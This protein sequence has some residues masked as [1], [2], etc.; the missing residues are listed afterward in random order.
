MFRNLIDGQAADHTVF[1]LEW[2]ADHGLGLD[3]RDHVLL[4]RME[5]VPYFSDVLR[6]DRSPFPKHGGLD[7]VWIRNGDLNRAYMACEVVRG[8]DDPGIMLDLPDRIIR[9][10]DRT[11]I[12]EIVDDG[13]Q[14]M[15]QERL[16]IQRRTENEPGI[17]QRR[18]LSDLLPELHSRLFTVEV[19]LAKFFVARFH[20]VQ[21]VLHQL[22]S[23]LRFFAKVPPSVRQP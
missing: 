18:Q 22:C 1:D 12:M 19:G 20:N 4:K 11:V 7:A 17:V 15:L 9:G 10:D 14:D 21:L 5:A 23:S 6:Q 2:H 13:L 8:A 3:D 16:A